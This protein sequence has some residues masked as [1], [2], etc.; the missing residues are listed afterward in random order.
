ME[1]FVIIG[2]GGH[3]NSILDLVHDSGNKIDY[4]VGFDNN[5]AFFQDIP[6]VGIKDINNLPLNYKF[7]FGIGDFKIRNRILM[8]LPLNE[9]SSRFP[10]VIHRTSYVSTKARI[11]NGTVIFANTYVGPNTTVGTFCVLNTNV[12]VEHNCSLGDYNSIAPST[13]IAGGVTTGSKCFFGM[14]SLI[15]NNVSIGSESIIAA[16][17]FVNESVPENSFLAGNPAMVRSQ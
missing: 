12:T 9:I 7:I 10:P 6:V 2:T 15:S 4:F 11:G 16:N 13:T 1:R 5:I 8:E 14:G 17:S 3:A